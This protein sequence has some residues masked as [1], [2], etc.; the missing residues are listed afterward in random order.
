[1]PKQKEWKPSLLTRHPA[2][3]EL[4]WLIWPFG[5]IRNWGK[6]WCTWDGGFVPIS[7]P[8][9]ALWWPIKLHQHM[10]YER[11]TIWWWRERHR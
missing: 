4:G 2:L 5:L 6:P 11:S 8:I 1:M 9:P 10:L 7:S 3:A